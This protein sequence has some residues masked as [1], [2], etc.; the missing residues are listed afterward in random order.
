MRG[1][2]VL[3]ILL[4]LSLPAPAVLAQGTLGELRGEVREPRAAEPE[5]PDDEPSER[6]KPRKT[7]R[8]RRPRKGRHE[9][10]CMGEFA[11]GFVGALLAPF[12]WP[13]LY[14]IGAAATSPFWGPPVLVEDDY[15]TGGVFAAFPY[16][17]NAR[18]F[19]LI[20]P[21]PSANLYPWSM[22]VRG[23][24][25]DNFDGLMR[26]G[27]HVL[28]ESVHR[29]GVDSALDYRRESL[30]GGVHD[31]LW[32]GDVNAVFRFAQSERLMMR[33]GLGFNWLSD[34]A[35]SDFG[36]NFTYGGDFFPRKPWIVSAEI[37]WGRLGRAALFHA[38]AT[39]GVSLRA[40]E[41]F[42]G[43]D[44]YDVGNSQLGGFVSG[45]RYWY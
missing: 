28:W 18:G 37:D 5:E 42:A 11:G 44:Y 13:A 34:A 35:A 19:M 31:S 7:K 9:H 27:G 15:R 43:Y 32:T 4:A 22:R 23:E 26:V 39:A 25:A 12:V 38:R 45:V 10:D 29:F 21:H 24:H 33:T 41:V 6:E 40:I 2:T 14:S 3:A 16:D 30:G 36:F 1:A 8:R 20:D 17:E